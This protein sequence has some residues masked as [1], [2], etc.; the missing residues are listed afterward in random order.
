MQYICD[1]KSAIRHLES[2]IGKLKATK[3]LAP[4]MDVILEIGRLRNKNNNIERSFKWVRSHQSKTLDADEKLNDRAD[5]LAT[6]CRDN[7]EQGL[8]PTDRNSIMLVPWQPSK[9]VER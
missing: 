6:F 2:D 5:Y 8:V 4:D 7:V 3:P 1:S 9:Y